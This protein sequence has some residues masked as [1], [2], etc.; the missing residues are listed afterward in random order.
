MKVTAHVTSTL[1]AAMRA[2]VDRS[3][4][5][6]WD[7]LEDIGE[8]GEEFART[9]AG[10]GHF[11]STISHDV[12]RAAES[13]TVGSKAPH[14]HII[15]DGRRPGRMPPPALIAD[16]FALDAHDAF[17]VA[18]AIGQGGTPAANIFRDTQRAMELDVRRRVSEFTR[19][20]IRLR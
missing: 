3:D 6:Y 17:Q 9:F 11:G 18:R 16:V 10:H 8:A 13:V 2:A 7:L 1:P 4:R 12:D 14:A 19:D 20:M 5:G 15:E